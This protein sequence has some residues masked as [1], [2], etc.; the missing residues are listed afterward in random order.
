MKGTSPTRSG[1][2]P[3]RHRSTKIE[4]RTFNLK[5]EGKS[6]T[7][8]LPWGSKLARRWDECGDADGRDCQLSRFKGLE[9]EGLFGAVHSPR[10]PTGTKLL[11]FPKMLHDSGYLFCSRRRSSMALLLSFRANTCQ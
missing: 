5:R 7:R 9:A 8:L 11:V 10:N 4:F 3:A 2:W 1:C 6:W